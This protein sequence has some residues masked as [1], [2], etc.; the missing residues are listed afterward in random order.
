VTTHAELE[1]FLGR[2]AT[3]V[4]RLT[5]AVFSVALAWHA[6][7]ASMEYAG[8]GIGAPWELAALAAFADGLFA[9]Y[10]G[11]ALAR[12]SRPV[13]RV[14]DRQVEWGSAFALSGKR[15]RL[16]L[17]AIGSLAWK[18]PKR[19]RLE[20]REGGEIVLHLAEIDATDRR[21]V[22]EAIQQRIRPAAPP[23]PPR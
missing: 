17:A 18:T 22:F 16:P 15:R 2:R 4:T 9:A 20:T 10:C 13:I 23:V 21:A 11:R 19:L 8:R 3:R 7:L 12:A 5:V 6:W 1:F 14:D